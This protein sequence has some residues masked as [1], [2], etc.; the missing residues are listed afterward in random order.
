MDISQSI[1]LHTLHNHL[2]IKTVLAILSPEDVEN[3]Q[4]SRN[5]FLYLYKNN[6]LFPQTV[7]EK[8]IIEI[9]KAFR[10]SGNPH[11]GKL[12]RNMFKKVC[13]NRLGETD[14]SFKNECLIEAIFERFKLDRLVFLKIQFL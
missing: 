12:T 11:E 2:N 7:N 9:W 4:K 14:P 1:S 5:I 13:A 3:F 10:E 6:V 8:R